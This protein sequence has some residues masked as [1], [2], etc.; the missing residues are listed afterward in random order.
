MEIKILI[1]DDTAVN[2][3]LL[4][5]LLGPLSYTL[6]KA[7]SGKEALDCL[8]VTEPDLILLDVMMPG[9]SGFE[10]LEKIRNSKKTM[11]IP[12]I[13]LTALSDRENRIKGIDAGADDFISKPFDK[14]ELV[15]KVKTQVRL[16]VLR[17][18]I[19][20][21]EKLA[22]VMD[23]M[24]EGVVLTDDSFNVS[25]INNTAS[26][27][28][29]MEGKI[30]N[31]G[32]FLLE[33]Y[34]QAVERKD[35]NGS[36]IIKRPASK[37]FGPLYLSVEYKQ[38]IKAGEDKGS[39]V[40]VLKDVTGEYT[41]NKMKADFLSLISHKLRTPLTVISSYA[42]M[43]GV[44]VTDEK[45]RDMAI[46]IKRNSGIMGNLIDRI[47]YF[48]E[49]DNVTGTVSTNLLDLRKL[50]EKLTALYSKRC[51]L[52]TDRDIVSLENRKIAVVEELIE[53]AI[54]FNDKND[55]VLNIIIDENKI[56][57]ED[58]GPGIPVEE[59]EKVFEPFYQ[60]YKDFSGNTAGAGLGLAIV[61]RM[62]ESEDMA[63]SLETGGAGGLRVVILNIQNVS[64]P[65]QAVKLP[66]II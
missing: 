52:I 29:G 45:L 31:F 6:I 21:K 8:E 14:A 40:F 26:E 13:L 57:I 47:L 15:S 66:A 50:I 41:K 54:K 61:K 65:I 10:V 32:L 2:I 4:E 1:V 16:S 25:Q 35:E 58:N 38:S 23:L 33:K 49:I 63:V 39:F 19:D 18:Q 24:F 9:M 30:E 36:F 27:F 3:E 7:S 62:L 59:R 48:V 37:N 17:R 44:L 64:M 22:G 28:L 53:N 34:G 51:E 12:V 20:E 11:T 42:K 55:M 43:L 56:I 46:A 60:I 5:A